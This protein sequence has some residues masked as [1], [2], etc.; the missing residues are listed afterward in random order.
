D[1]LIN[2]FKRVKKAVLF[3]GSNA[4][5][6][7]Y[8]AH[9]K[10]DNQWVIYNDEKVAKSENPPK[11]LAYLYFYK[12]CMLK[13]GNDTILLG[14]IYRPPRVKFNKALN[15]S[16]LHA[17][18]LYDEKKITGWCGD[19]NFPLIKWDE[20]FSPSS[21]NTQKDSGLSDPELESRTC[22]SFEIDGNVAFSLGRISEI[23][24]S[25]KSDKSTGP[26]DMNPYFLKFCSKSIALPLSI[27]FNNSLLNGEVPELWKLANVTP[28]HKNGSK[29]ES[30]NYRPVSLTFVPGK[31]MERIVREELV[32]YLIENKLISPKQ[33]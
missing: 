6:G 19:F 24:S 14:C 17:R 2:A 21:F 18:K 4:N 31:I 10:K 30:S 28:L 9:I 27:I 8:V 20:N 16:L 3:C 5:V 1:K 13:T 23:L 32:Y 25:L 33:H 11:N 29:L 12:R 7:H 26:D 22:K 15:E